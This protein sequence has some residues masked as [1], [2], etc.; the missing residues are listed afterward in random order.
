[1]D[2][3][4]ALPDGACEVRP[5]GPV[6]GSLAAP[7]S[8]SLTNR[9]LVLAALAD[10]DSVL[11]DPLDSD[12]SAAMGALVVGLGARVERGAGAW[13]VRGTRGRP[14]RPAGPLHAGLS[15]TTMRFG[16]AIAALA[17][18]PVTVTGDPPLERRPI[19]ALTAALG[20]LGAQAAD[21]GGYPPVRLAGGGLAG[22]E[23]TVDVSGSSQFA[24]AVLLVAPY[25]R[26]D[27]TVRN[28][29]R[30]AGAYV[31]MTV[32]AMRDWGAAVT[33]RADGWSVR[34]GTGYGARDR[35]VEYDASA[36][37]HL[38]ALA[39]ATGG[40]VTVGNATEGSLQPDAGVTAVFERM[41]ARL[42][43]DGDAVTVDGPDRPA[44][45]DVD[46]SD[47]PDQV[48]TIAALAALAEGATTI[49]GVA[50]ARG[51]ETDRLAALADELGSLGVRVDERPDGLV[52]HGGAP[53]GPARLRARGDHRLA[54]AFAALAARVP[55]VVIEDPGC[56]TKTYPRFWA[57]VRRLGVDWRGAG[58]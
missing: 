26:A 52:V 32:A 8:K 5:S 11:R 47:T 14:A 57:D 13:R 12:D 33:D 43:R 1:M 27:V 37:A 58:P 2:A 36:A 39:V 31:A 7:A 49:R 10:G 15:G 25:A 38:L 9:L 4:A 46:L 23:V 48:T 34:A 51:H 45:V 28:S 30:A 17:P 35:P 56:V 19:G 18:G 21:R 44:P 6:R 42:R 54:M 41:G 22:G 55:G 3:V 29:G 20:A 16:T 53:R 50:V 40:R 24:S